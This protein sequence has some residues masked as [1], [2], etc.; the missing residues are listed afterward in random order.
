MTYFDE[1]RYLRL[2]PLEAGLVLDFEH[3]SG[4]AVQIVAR[5]QKVYEG[6]DVKENAYLDMYGKVASFSI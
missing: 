5:R 1:V 2:S 6:K 4:H 3:K